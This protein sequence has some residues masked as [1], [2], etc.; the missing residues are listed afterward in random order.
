MVLC[1]NTFNTC[2]KIVKEKVNNKPLTGF[3]NPNF[4]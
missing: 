3:G 4:I 1:V 2:R